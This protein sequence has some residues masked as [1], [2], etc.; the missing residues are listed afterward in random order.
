MPKVKISHSVDQLADDLYRCELVPGLLMTAC[1]LVLLMAP[2]PLRPIEI[3]NVIDQANER[4]GSARG[5]PKMVRKVLMRLIDRGEVRMINEG[6]YRTYERTDLLKPIFDRTNPR[7][8]GTLLF[9]GVRWR[10]PMEDLMIATRAGVAT[11]G[12]GC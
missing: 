5:L 10:P 6:S 3:S 1:R 7:L 4:W 8:S 12:G 2:R 9:T 11:A